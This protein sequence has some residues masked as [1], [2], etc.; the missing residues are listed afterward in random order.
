MS[1]FVTIEHVSEV[2][3]GDGFVTVY[4]SDGHY[5]FDVYLCNESDDAPRMVGGGSRTTL[6]EA[7]EA[8]RN[9]YETELRIATAP[10]A[11]RLVN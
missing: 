6:G 9:M 4:L 11:L 3:F 1:D 5:C 8:A 10:V 7:Q 2:D